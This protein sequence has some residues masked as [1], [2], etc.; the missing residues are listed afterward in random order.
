MKTSQLFTKTQKSD[1][2]DEASISARLLV[3]GGFVEKIA[4]GVY[5]VLPLGFRVLAN[6][7][8]I[9]AQEMDALGG[10]RLL[11]SALVPKKNWE[12][13]GRWNGLDVL[14]KLDREN[15]ES[16][17]LGATHEEEVVPLAQKFVFSYKDLPFSV[18]QIQTKFRNEPRAKSGLLRLREFMMKDLYSFHADEADLDK[19]YEK[20]KK[21]YFS[22]YKR[23]GIK[24]I[25]YLTLASGGTFSKFSHE[26]QTATDAGEDTIFVCK[27][28]GIA[29]NKE[30]KGL[31]PECPE[32]GCGGF[33]EKK[34]IE[35]G[36]IFKLKTK[37]S[38]PF[39]LQFTGR[40]G[41]KKTVVMGCYGIGLTRLM[42]AV[43]EANNDANG[44]IWPDELAPFNACLVAVGS[45]NRAS[46]KKIRAAAEKLYQDLQKAGLEVIY[47]DRDDKSTGEKFKDCDLLGMP[48]RLIVSEKTLAKKSVELKKRA[49]KDTSL[50]KLDRITKTL[51]G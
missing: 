13:T 4:A 14:F 15:G 37:Y 9:V 5:A 43:V 6:I 47:D 49:S 48:S 27:K 12:V 36:N 28:C 16:Y 10:Q 20:A 35:V 19:F 3:R 2:G 25:T 46:D 39:G 42:G 21:A 45:N 34:C 29:I 51:C 1:P 24:N 32:C 30:I 50:V 41:Q 17:A 8:A 22:V 40:N 18:Y 44:I 33:E 26:F 38:E 11:M 23:C 31:Y 7:E